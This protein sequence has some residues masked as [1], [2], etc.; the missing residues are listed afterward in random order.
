MVNISLLVQAVFY[1]FWIESA[2]SELIRPKI[3]VL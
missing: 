2:V 1:L 3:N